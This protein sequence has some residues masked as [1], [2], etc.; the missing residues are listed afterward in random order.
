MFTRWA[1]HL[2]C[3]PRKF[4]MKPLKWEQNILWKSSCSRKTEDV[5]TKVI[6]QLNRSAPSVHL[7]SHLQTSI[8]K[9]C[10]VYVLFF[11]ALQSQHNRG[12]GNLAIISPILQVESHCWAK[13]VARWQMGTR[14]LSPTSCCCSKKAV[15]LVRG[16]KSWWMELEEPEDAKLV[17][18]PMDWVLVTVM[19]C[20]GLYSVLCVCACA[21]LVTPVWLGHSLLELN[22]SAWMNSNTCSQK[23]CRCIKQAMT[24]WTDRHCCWNDW[25]TNRRRYTYF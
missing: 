7:E 13:R 10:F 11:V 23:L 9:S 14:T 3:K 21:L 25:L 8:G 4:D 1:L 24:K 6:N 20:A 15:P 12:R 16:G 2:T 19:P 22:V 5:S 18:S 17:Q